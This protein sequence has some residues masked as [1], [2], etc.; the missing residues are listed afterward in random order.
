MALARTV[1]QRRLASSTMAI[2]ESIRRRLERQ[3]DLLEELEDLPPAQRAKR[4]GPIQGRLAD[5]EQDE[6]DLDDAERDL[7]VDEFT[8]AVEL[9]QLRPKSRRCEIS[10]PGTAR[11]RSRRRTRNSP[12]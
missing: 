5:A 3:Q 1:L 10:C 11:A 4:L 9:D 12:P 7:L 6:D 8:A 2:D